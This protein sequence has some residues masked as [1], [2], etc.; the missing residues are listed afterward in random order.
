MN[1]ETLKK[2]C[3]AFDIP[4][5]ITDVLLLPNLCRRAKDLMVTQAGQGP[6]TPATGVVKVVILP[7]NAQVQ[8]RVGTWMVPAITVV[9]DILLVNAQAQQRVGTRM[10]PAI[11]VGEKDILLVNAPSQRR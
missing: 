2:L 5:E 1:I 9:V 7:V 3:L 8:Q 10:V 4:W 6:P 11:N